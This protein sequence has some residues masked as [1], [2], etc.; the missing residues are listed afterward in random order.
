M[1]GG[2]RQL[3]VRIGLHTGAPLAITGGY[4]GIDVHSAARVMAAGHGGQVLV[5]ETTRAL[6]GEQVALRD[7]GEHRLKDLSSPR[8]LYQLGADGLGVADR[9]HERGLLLALTDRREEN[10]HAVSARRLRS[11]EGRRQ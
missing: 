2:G 1:A 6:L 8:R 10:D 4:V 11:N 7:L 5:S 3:R 9:D